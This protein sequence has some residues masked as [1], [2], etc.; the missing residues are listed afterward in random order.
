MPGEKEEPVST[1]MLA[2]QILRP[3]LALHEIEITGNDPALT[4]AQST[5]VAMVLHEMATNAIK[6]GSLLGNDGKLVINVA[7]RVSGLDRPL[8][9]ITWTEHC[10]FE[11][12]CSEDGIIEGF[13]SRLIRRSIGQIQGEADMVWRN[14]GLQAT[15]TFPM[16]DL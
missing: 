15:L 4:P 14:T 16:E 3:Y 9:V 12:R 7:T 2:K 5:S 8:V 11:L 6:Y 13:G 10:A 1:Q